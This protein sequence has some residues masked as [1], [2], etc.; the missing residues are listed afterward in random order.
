MSTLFLGLGKVNQSLSSCVD[1]EKWA[2]VEESASVC[3]YERL[4]NRWELRFREAGSFDTFAWSRWL[5]ADVFLSPGIDPRRPFFK[6][7][8]AYEKRELDFFSKRFSGDIIAVTGTDGKSTLTVQLG[9]LLRRALPDKHIFVGGNLGTAMADALKDFYDLAVLEVSSFQ[10]ERLR[11]TR[12]SAAIIANL[13]IDHLDRYD[14]V[15]DYHAAKWHMLSFADH[16]FYPH[17]CRPVSSLPRSE[18]YYS[19]QDSLTD[20]LKAVSSSLAG[21]LEFNWNEDLLRDLPVLPHRF[22]VEMRSD[23]CIIVDDSKATTVHA[24]LYA[25]RRVREF[26]GRL[27]LILGGRYKGDDFSPIG[28]LLTGADRLEVYGEAAGIIT[29]ALRSGVENMRVWPTL[30]ALLDGV[31]PHLKKDDILLLSP[32]CSSFDEF[33]NFEERGDFFKKRALSFPLG[34]QAS[35]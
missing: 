32:G 34:L 13:D 30:N 6:S 10:C 9:E 22:E 15:Q 29:E 8:E 18:A 25:L 28:N 31:L 4:G 16:V 2:F 19:N 3:V 35:S 21:I 27:H 17:E 11:E 24:V 26:K 12:L 14:S 7:I 1:G 20:I 5:P 33:E 23:G